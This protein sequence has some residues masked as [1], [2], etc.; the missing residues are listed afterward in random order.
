MIV[1]KQQTAV[2]NNWLSGTRKNIRF[3]F[4]IITQVHSYNR[5]S[6]NTKKIK[7]LQNILHY[8]T[9]LSITLYT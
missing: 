6:K 8:I 2:Y 9:I 7:T 4:K 1:K 3:N 5:L